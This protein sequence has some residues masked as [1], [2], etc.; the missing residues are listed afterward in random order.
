MLAV[1]SEG[2]GSLNVFQSKLREICQDFGVAHASGKPAQNVIDGDPH[3]P[4]AGF[5]TPFTRVDG[6]EW[7]SLRH[8]MILNAG[9][10]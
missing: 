9:G 3:V 6:D 10:G 4:D 5:S 7:M 1:C 2:K 8:G